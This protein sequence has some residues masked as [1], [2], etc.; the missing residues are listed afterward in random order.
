[1]ETAKKFVVLSLGKRKVIIGQLTVLRVPRFRIFAD[2]VID[3]GALRYSSGDSGVALGSLVERP[4][5]ARCRGDFCF[6][7]G[8]SVAS[9]GDPS[10]VGGDAVSRGPLGDGLP[11]ARPLPPRVPLG[12]G[13]AVALP[14]GLAE[15][16]ACGLA[17]A[18]L[19]GEAVALGEAVAS[20]EAVPVT[21]AAVAAGDAV[22]AVAAPVAVAVPP[23]TEVCPVTPTWPDTP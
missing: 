18:V 3:T 23:V 1:M 22:A 19:V 11:P 8:L 12:D 7:L 6:S 14:Y 17:D 5:V 13:L 15:A 20:G 21:P 16:L 2:L 4:C 10:V 9:D